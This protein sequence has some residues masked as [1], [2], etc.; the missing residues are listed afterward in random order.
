[1]AD[2]ERPVAGAVFSEEILMTDPTTPNSPLPTPETT[3]FSG[4]NP[5]SIA[6]TANT[7]TASASASGL[8]TAPADLAG[9]QVNL[10]TRMAANP[11]SLTFV[12][13]PAANA[14]G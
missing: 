12:P 8:F 5:G 14:R 11:A 2:L 13:R 4:T 6:N 7:W 3:C 1:M 10:E 9:E